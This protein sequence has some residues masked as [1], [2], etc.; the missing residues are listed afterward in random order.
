MSNE[1]WPVGI[2]RVA[3]PALDAQAAGRNLEHLAHRLAAQLHRLRRARKP[4]RDVHD[5]TAGRQHEGRLRPS[6]LL[7]HAEHAVLV[8]LVG[9]DAPVQPAGDDRGRRG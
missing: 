9:I 2:L 8:R 5:V 6:F 4:E 7:E 3:D 1:I